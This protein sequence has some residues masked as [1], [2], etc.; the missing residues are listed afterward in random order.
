MKTGV[1]VSE[2]ERE[3]E[4][5]REIKNMAVCVRR[6]HGKISNMIFI[7]TTNIYEPVSPFTR[8]QAH[9]TNVLAH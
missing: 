7:F 5:E 9:K 4:K 1:C 3:R 2:R 6:V 8:K